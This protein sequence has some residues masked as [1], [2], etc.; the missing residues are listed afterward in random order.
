GYLHT[1]WSQPGYD[2]ETS[3]IHIHGSEGMLDVNDSA[4]RL[5][6]RCARLRY[7]RGVHVRLR[8]DLERA[9]FNLSPNYGGEG[10]YREDQDFVDACLQRRPAQVGWEEGLAVQRV[11]DAVY[12]SHGQRLELG[13]QQN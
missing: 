2:V 9:D 10:Y 6:L 3:T 12:R 8:G 13:A 1:S 5:E 11:I 7:G 4:L